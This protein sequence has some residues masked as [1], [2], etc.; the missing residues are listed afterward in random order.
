MQ[1]TDWA[2][3]LPLLSK[4]MK[5]A[6]Q[7]AAAI[8]ILLLGLQPALAGAACA[9]SG[10]ARSACPLCMSS[11]GAG[12]P[13]AR[14]LAACCNRT[15]LRAAV[16]PAIPAKPRSAAASARISAGLELQFS[17]VAPSRWLPVAV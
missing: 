3:I 10:A 16:L 9:M 4:Q 8:M 2:P 6:S 14:G 1:H 5:R 17:Y 13:M 12:C 7:F 15:D 11:M